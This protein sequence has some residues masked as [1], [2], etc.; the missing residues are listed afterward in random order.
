MRDGA[1]GPL[2]LPNYISNNW[3]L[4]ILANEYR[5]S[6]GNSNILLLANVGSPGRL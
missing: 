4:V 1:L 3:L 6:S 2:P 5:V